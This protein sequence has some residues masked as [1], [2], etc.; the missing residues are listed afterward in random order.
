[1]P[2]S[3]GLSSE[4][5]IVQDIMADPNINPNLLQAAINTLSSRLI[6]CSQHKPHPLY[7]KLIV[8]VLTTRCQDLKPKLHPLLMVQALTT[9][10]QNMEQKPHPTSSNSP[11]DCQGSAIE[12]SDSNSRQSNHSSNNQP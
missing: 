11:F 8:Q 3:D 7:G 1:M 5:T 10:G 9:R 6:Q 12:S 4:D 2:Q